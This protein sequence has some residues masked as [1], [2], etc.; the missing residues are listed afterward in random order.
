MAISYSKFL[1]ATN[2]DFQLTVRHS[3]CRY[4]SLAIE[5]RDMWLSWNQAIQTSNSSDLPPGLTP[6]DQLLYICGC[7][8]L[9]E[10]PTLRDYYDDSL[11]S[12]EKSAPEFRRMQFVK[13]SL[14]ISN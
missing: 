8:F 10:G 6:E 11:R 12:M 3:W 13:V 7:Y 14:P 4:Q 1:P 9:T 2:Q 5:A